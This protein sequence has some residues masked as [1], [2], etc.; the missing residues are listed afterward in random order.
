MTIIRPLKLFKTRYISVSLFHPWPL[1]CE[2]R[3]RCQIKSSNSNKLSFCD[4]KDSW[5]LDYPLRSDL[6]D[7]EEV[8][9]FINI[10]FIKEVGIACIASKLNVAGLKTLTRM[11]A[12][13]NHQLG[14]LLKLSKICDGL[15]FVK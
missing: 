12:I 14:P 10:D 3:S 9:Y 5:L 6:S 7:E 13:K 1:P 15:Q 4:L 11:I 8:G 2:K